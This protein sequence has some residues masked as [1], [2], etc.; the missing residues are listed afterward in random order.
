MRKLSH[1]SNK[2]ATAS[3]LRFTSIVRSLTSWA[4]NALKM[5]EVEFCARICSAFIEEGIFIDYWLGQVNFHTAV[6][7]KAGFWAHWESMPYSIGPPGR[8]QNGC[9]IMF[10]IIYWVQFRNFSMAN[11]I[12]VTFNIDGVFVFIEEL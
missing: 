2:R 7:P 6:V 1:P 11:Q 12:L 3:Y 9:T 8:D 4:F 5:V 10:I